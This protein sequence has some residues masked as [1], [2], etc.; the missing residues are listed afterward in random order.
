VPAHGRDRSPAG[1]PA[2]PEGIAVSTL[3]CRLLTASPIF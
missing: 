3:T 2:A 1:P